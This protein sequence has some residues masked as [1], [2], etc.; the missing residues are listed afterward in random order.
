MLF[1]LVNIL[2]PLKIVEMLLAKISTNKK[3]DID[4]V[5]QVGE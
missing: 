3:I 1:L 5:R 2:G 4:S